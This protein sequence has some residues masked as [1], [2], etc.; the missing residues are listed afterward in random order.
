MTGEGCVFSVFRG[1]ILLF[2][3]LSLLISFLLL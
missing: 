2:M 3:Y 1:Y